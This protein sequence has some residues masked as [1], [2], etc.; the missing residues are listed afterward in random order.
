LIAIED[1]V[2]KIPATVQHQPAVSITEDGHR[3]SRPRVLIPKFQR[4]IRIIPD[5]TSPT[6]LPTNAV[7]LTL[8]AITNLLLPTRYPAWPNRP[9]EETRH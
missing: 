9:A 4:T 3:T 2:I 5:T 7:F 1:I 6:T 8:I